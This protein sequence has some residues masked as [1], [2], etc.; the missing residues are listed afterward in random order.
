MRLH[1]MQQKATPWLNEF[2]LVFAL[3][4]TAMVLVLLAMLFT[5]T[6]R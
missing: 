3:L 1:P 5:A 2:A 4:G 6:A